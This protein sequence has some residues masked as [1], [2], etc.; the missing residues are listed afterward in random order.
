MAPQPHVPEV[1]MN[2]LRTLTLLSLVSCA[3][4]DTDTGAD[5]N[6]DTGVESDTSAD[7]SVE[8]DSETESDSESDDDTDSEA[9]V[10]ADGDGFTVQ[11]GDCDDALAS[12]NPGAVEVC[13]DGVD[14]DCDG[15]DDALAQ[16]TLLGPT[17]YASFAADSPFQALTFG[18]FH[19]DD[20]EAGVVSAPVSVS[21]HAVS[22]SYGTTNIDSVD[23]DDGVIDGQCVGCDALNASG[24][25]TFTFD[26]TAL[27]G[28][29]THVG[30]VW[31]D[32][33]GDLTFTVEGECGT[34]YTGVHP[35]TAD[36]VHTGTTDEDRFYGVI[37]LAG[38]KSISLTQ[39]GAGIE[40]DH[41]QF[42]R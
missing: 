11:Q 27:G 23:G 28:L 21:T 41:L 39:P 20:F 19:L 10:D 13:G 3:G 9:D 26:A 38:V 36:S 37:A 2:A 18:W 31:T 24:G 8:T 1:P 34:L 7:T 40:V 16:G 12:V 14:Q 6:E 4:G 22:S 33:L 17:P 5:T 25:I 32:G 42:G 29:P 35:T 15:I 30:L